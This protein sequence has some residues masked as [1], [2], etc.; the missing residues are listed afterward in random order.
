MNKITPLLITSGF[1]WQI[2]ITAGGYNCEKLCKE[3]RELF[4]KIRG[5]IES[6]RMEKSF[7]L[8]EMLEAAF[9][10]G[11]LRVVPFPEFFN[12]SLDSWEDADWERVQFIINSQD[13]VLVDEFMESL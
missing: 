10:A 2:P 11:D 7:R 5:D 8:L 13:R 9:F 12:G 6:E 4:S 3:D 1:F